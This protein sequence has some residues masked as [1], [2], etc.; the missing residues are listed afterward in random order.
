M[1]HFTKILDNAT[2][3]AKSLGNSK[4]GRF[5]VLSRQG[6]NCFVS[7]VFDMKLG[8]RQHVA[9]M[10]IDT[11]LGKADLSLTPAFYDSK[12]FKRELPA[13]KEFLESEF[14]GKWTLSPTIER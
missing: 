6:T 9:T 14:H 4:M 2:D 5:E 3:G 11:L 8:Y 1:G 7:D 12:E 10:S 13:L